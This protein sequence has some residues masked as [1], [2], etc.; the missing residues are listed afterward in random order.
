MLSHMCLLTQSV[1]ILWP[2]GG[3]VTPQASPSF[4]WSHPV[5]ALTLEA[6]ERCRTIRRAPGAPPVATF[7]LL[8]TQSKGEL[9]PPLGRR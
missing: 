7:C 1:P 3:A 9:I 5:L 4:S 2:W 8:H 6:P